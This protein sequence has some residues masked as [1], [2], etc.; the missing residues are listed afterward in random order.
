M[1]AL[2]EHEKRIEQLLRQLKEP[3]A[4]RADSSS[5]D[6]VAQDLR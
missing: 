1:A 3:K 6:L 5:S 2:L 4:V